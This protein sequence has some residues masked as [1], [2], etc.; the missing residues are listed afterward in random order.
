MA[1]LRESGSREALTA[2]AAKLRIL[3]RIEIA[4]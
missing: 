4:P 1:R 3:G 2:T